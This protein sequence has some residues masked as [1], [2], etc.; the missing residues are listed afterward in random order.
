VATRQEV[1]NVLLAQLLRERGLIAAPE[2]ITRAVA[3]GSTHMPD[4]L[5][6]LQGLR[7]AIEGDFA[8]RSGAEDAVVAQT[9]DRVE[10]GI[11]HIGAAVLYPVALRHGEFGQ[12]KADLAH[13]AL[14]FAVITESPDPVSFGTGDV[15]HL[16][17]ALRRAYGQLVE[18]KVLERAVTLLG[19]GIDGFTKALAG[20]PATAER[21]ATALGI[22]ETPRASR[23]G[24]EDE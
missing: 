10:K 23:R 24:G 13:A 20:Q 15:E 21:F 6:D 9:R 3:D 7:L 17:E 11:A 22:K 2:Q 19:H 14:R 16:A 18:D 8:S 1:L 12:A 5:V 4:V